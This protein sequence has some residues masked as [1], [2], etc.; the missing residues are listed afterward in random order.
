[1]IAYFSME[2][3]VDPQVP[4]YAGGLGVLAGDI[5]RAAADTGLKFVAVTLLHRKG[6]FRQ[7]LDASG[8]QR[9]EPTEWN[10]DAAL[11]PVSTRVTV[12]IGGRP[13]LVRAWR[14]SVHGIDGASVPV[15][16]LDTDVDENLP[17]DRAL[18]HSLYGGGG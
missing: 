17:E 4:T 7:R 1:M 10:V 9:E 18:T 3:G 12:A 11:E 6:Y 15:F 5:V 14:R 2:I 8:R 13:V 16:F